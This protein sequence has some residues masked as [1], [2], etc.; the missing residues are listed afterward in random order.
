MGSVVAMNK[1]SCSKATKDLSWDLSSL[2]RDQTHVPCITRQIFKH[3]TMR[4]VPRLE[5]FHRS[6][7]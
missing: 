5:V 7:C 3:W 6:L 1:F 4:D 2:T